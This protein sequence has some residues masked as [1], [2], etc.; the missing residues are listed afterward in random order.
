MTSV[1]ITSFI[2]LG[3]L[4]ASLRLR[5]RLGLSCVSANRRAQGRAVQYLT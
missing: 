3:D 4:I 2:R 5:L 1:S